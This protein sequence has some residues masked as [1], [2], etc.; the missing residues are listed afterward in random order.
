MSTWLPLKVWFVFTECGFPLTQSSHTMRRETELSNDGEGMQRGFD[1][2]RKT[3]ATLPWNVQA[4]KV[5][6]GAVDSF[7]CKI[8]HLIGSSGITNIQQLSHT[9]WQEDV[10]TELP[11]RLLYRQM[12]KLRRWTSTPKYKICNFALKCLNTEFFP[13][14]LTMS[15]WHWFLKLNTTEA[16]VTSSHNQSLSSN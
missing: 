13:S 9:R 8:L 6:A 4:I 16:A 7:P 3:W 12:I 15:H 1:L 14:H 10:T 5:R 11:H 2:R